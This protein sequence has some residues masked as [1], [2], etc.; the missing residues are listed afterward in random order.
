MGENKSS[1]DALTEFCEKNSGDINACLKALEKT[2][3]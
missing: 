2:G 3:I 1:L